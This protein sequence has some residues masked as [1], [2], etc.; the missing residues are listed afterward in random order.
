MLETL[1]AW[2]GFILV[3]I[4]LGT[5]IS[6]FLM[7]YGAGLAG[8]VKSGFWRSLFAS[9]CSAGIT[10]LIVLAVLV[11][12]SPIKP[13]Y[14]L[15]AGLLLSV[16]IIKGIYKAS[17]FEALVPWLFFLIA[18]ALSIFFGAELAM[19]GLSDLLAILP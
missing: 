10:Y 5:S 15:A 8:V 11:F 13:L 12:G 14:G 3:L 18:Q 2:I 1:E 19:G 9:L 4:F 6:C 16:F 17:I 7:W